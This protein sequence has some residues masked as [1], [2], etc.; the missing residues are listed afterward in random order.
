[1]P[2]ETNIPI[3]PPL[4]REPRLSDE[5]KAEIDAM[6]VGGSLLMQD[7]KAIR[8]VAARLYT[9]GKKS[10]RRVVPGGYRIWRIA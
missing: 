9:Q 7:D 1:M 8:C 6:P 5:L 4:A 2:I 10:R 3:P